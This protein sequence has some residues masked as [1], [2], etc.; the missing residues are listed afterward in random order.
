MLKVLMGVYF[1]KNAVGPDGPSV[2]QFPL[3]TQHALKAIYDRNWGERCGLYIVCVPGSQVKLLPSMEVKIL[4][5]LSKDMVYGARIVIHGL[6]FFIVIDDLDGNVLIDEA[7]VIHRP[8]S[9]TFEKG[10]CKHRIVLTWD[11]TVPGRGITVKAP[12]SEE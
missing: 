10:H 12:E 3:D 1:S 6:E 4:C 7:N 9:L 2:S 5:G 8:G 11:A